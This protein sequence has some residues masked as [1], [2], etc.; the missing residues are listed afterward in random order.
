MMTD[1]DALAEM[2]AQM[3]IVKLEN[4]FP[5]YLSLELVTS[6]PSEKEKNKKHT[7]VHNN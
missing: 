6:L 7:P 2:S 4:S 3:H 5:R 1:N